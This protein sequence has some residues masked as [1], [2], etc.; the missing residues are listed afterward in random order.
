MRRGRPRKTD[1]YSCAK[2]GRARYVRGRY[3]TSFIAAEITYCPSCGYVYK[4]GRE[5]L[6]TDAVETEAAV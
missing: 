2:C 5:E 6:L 4:T 3:R 1:G